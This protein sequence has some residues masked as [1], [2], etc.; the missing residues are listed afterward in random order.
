MHVKFHLNRSTVTCELTKI[1]LI[2]Q[3]SCL[4]DSFLFSLRLHILTLK[5]YE[6]GVDVFIRNIALYL[7]FK[8]P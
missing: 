5:M 2:A 4:T 3:M 6:L 8:T 1:P 7:R